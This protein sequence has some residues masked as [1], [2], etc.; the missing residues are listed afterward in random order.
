MAFPYA[1]G[2]RVE[3]RETRCREEI[4]LPAA[5]TVSRDIRIESGK[6]K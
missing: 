1:P 3:E 5:G 2:K 4:I 6:G